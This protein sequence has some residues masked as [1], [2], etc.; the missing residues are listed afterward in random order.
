MGTQIGTREDFGA[1]YALKIGTRQQRKALQ[2]IKQEGI[3][4]DRT[5]ALW[6]IVVE[7]ER[8]SCRDRFAD[9][10][11]WKPT[12]KAVVRSRNVSR[13][14]TPQRH[15]MPCSTRIRRGFRRPQA[16]SYLRK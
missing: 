14:S 3:A 16:Q 1:K 15:G 13:V 11:F 10:T 2:E 6:G 7:T 5:G 12:L 9:F 4:I 8:H